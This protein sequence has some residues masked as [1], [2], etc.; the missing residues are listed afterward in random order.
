MSSPWLS[1]PL[2]DYEA[3]MSSNDV[4][5]LTALA[6]LFH[7]SLKRCVPESLAVLGV[8][9]GNGLESIDCTITKRIVGVDINQAFLD[10]V[11]QRFG[12]LPGLELH[13]CD[14]ARCDLNL[15][16]VAL[17]HA[18]LIFEHAGLGR[19]L[20]NALSLVAPGGKFSVVLQLPS[21]NGQAVA[22]TGYASIQSLKNDF[23]LIDV[24]DFQR[25]LAKHGFHL[26]EQDRCPVPA[27]K[28]LWLGMFA[29]S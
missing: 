3:H 11:Q 16:P 21:Q 22:C 9:G 20:A 28:A 7:R 23:R 27:G 26:L 18:A 10:V 24:D 25:L 13:R 15:S 17:V 14:L 4:Q 6:E 19:P 8:A 12:S 2:E 1:V 5:Q 29:K